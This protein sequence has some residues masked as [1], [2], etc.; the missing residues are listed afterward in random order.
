[1]ASPRFLIC[2]IDGELHWD[3]TISEKMEIESKQILQSRRKRKTNMQFSIEFESLFPSVSEEYEEEVWCVAFKFL[4][5]LVLAKV[6]PLIGL[7]VA[8]LD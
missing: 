5:R 8:K 2:L 4:T 6:R 7:T 3:R 1:M